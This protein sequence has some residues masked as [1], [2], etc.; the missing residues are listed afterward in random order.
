MAKKNYNKEEEKNKIILEQNKTQ[1]NE[2]QEELNEIKESLTI[3]QKEK[4][5][6]GLNYKNQIQRIK[7][8]YDRKIKEEEID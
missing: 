3:T 1:I 8:E 5:I 6:E 4:E 2:L 7:D